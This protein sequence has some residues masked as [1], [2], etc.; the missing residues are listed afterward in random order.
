MLLILRLFGNLLNPSFAKK[1]RFKIII[2]VDLDLI[3]SKNENVTGA[4]EFVLRV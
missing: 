4:L 3:L 1:L 2:L